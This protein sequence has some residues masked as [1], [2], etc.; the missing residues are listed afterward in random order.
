VTLS[1]PRADYRVPPVV[2]QGRRVVVKEHPGILLVVHAW[3]RA[4]AESILQEC[5]S[6]GD[7][8]LEEFRRSWRP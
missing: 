6:R 7:F 1:M 2:I 5:A 3:V 4:R 8:G